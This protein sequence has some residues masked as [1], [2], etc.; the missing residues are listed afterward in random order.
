MFYQ[1]LKHWVYQRFPAFINSV[2]WIEVTTENNQQNWS[3]PCECVQV[4][5]ENVG[6]AD[7]DT[8]LDSK[9]NQ[10]DKC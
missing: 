5:I 1:A 6:F 4:V 2:L 8:A 10:K 7:S 3:F 9:L